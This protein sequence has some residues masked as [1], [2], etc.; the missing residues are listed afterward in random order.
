MAEEINKGELE[1]PDTFSTQFVWKFRTLTITVLVKFTPLQF[2]TEMDHIEIVA[3]EPDGHPLPIT[4]SGY[5]STWHKRG[6]FENVEEAA[7]A[8]K[9]WLDK[10]SSE[11]EWLKAV[12]DAEQPSLF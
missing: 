4:P 3:I 11:S 10:R 8:V 1:M 12:A 2:G 9:G 5:R 7:Q 6:R